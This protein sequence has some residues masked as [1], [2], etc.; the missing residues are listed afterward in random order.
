MAIKHRPLSMLVRSSLETC[1]CTLPPNATVE[2]AVE[3]LCRRR[4]SA[5]AVVDGGRIQGIVTRTDILKLLK[6]NDSADPRTLPLA[7]VMT[8]HLVVSG[9][10]KPMREVLDDMTQAG[11]E[12]VAVLDGGELLTIVH[13]RD[14]MRSQIDAMQTDIHN[15][16]EYIDGL[17][18]AAQD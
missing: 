6:R 1:F 16:R 3:A 4:R 2:Q 5:V 18:H 17:H 11:I 10:E 12:H 7:R 9:P 14:I 13:E 8:K 15:L